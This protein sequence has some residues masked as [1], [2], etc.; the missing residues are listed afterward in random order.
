MKMI[1][2]LS[3]YVRNSVFE[4]KISEDYK[5]G[6]IRCLFLYLKYYSIHT[7]I[8]PVIHFFQFNIN[9]PIDYKNPVG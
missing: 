8:M 4:S 6:A 1:L 5:R 7:I 9:L 2:Y 3:L